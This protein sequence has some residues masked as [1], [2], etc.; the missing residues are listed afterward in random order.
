MPR[1][2]NPDWLTRAM[3]DG[4]ILTETV[5]RQAAIKGDGSPV[6][7]R[8]RRRNEQKF[9]TMVIEFAKLHG[10]VCAWFRPVRITRKSGGTYYE[11]P[12]GADGAGWPD[13]FMLRGQEA[14]AAEL[15]IYPNRMTP[16]QGEWLR[17]MNLIPGI[18][19]FCWFPTDWPEIEEILK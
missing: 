17:A 13:L 6:S 15:K 14:I 11:T 2:S 16:E 18:Q 5:V 9:Q 19:A 7:K 4:R 1:D 12:V 3:A 10:W 8:P